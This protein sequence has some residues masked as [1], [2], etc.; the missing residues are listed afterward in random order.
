[1][2]TG[3]Q[4]PLQPSVGGEKTNRWRVNTAESYWQELS[5]AKAWR[6]IY[7][8]HR[9]LVFPQKGL[10]LPPLFFISHPDRVTA[11]IVHHESPAIDLSTATLLLM[12]C[13]KDGRTFY[14]TCT[15]LTKGE[16]GRA[17][18]HQSFSF[19]TS[20]GV[21]YSGSCRSQL[22]QLIFTNRRVTHSL[23][24]CPPQLA[25]RCRL[26]F[27]DSVHYED[28]PSVSMKHDNDKSPTAA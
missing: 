14:G 4:K 28:N 15:E 24:H 25:A 21:T 23:L 5:D 20:P 18:S 10:V 22:D 11:S 1:M 16:G 27:V 8:E 9:S 13:S 6:G 7:A 2:R 3:P 12:P 19:D 26:F 17:G